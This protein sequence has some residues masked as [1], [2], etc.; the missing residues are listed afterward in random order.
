MHYHDE[1]LWYSATIAGAGSSASTIL[2]NRG[3]VLRRW[4]GRESPRAG[5]GTLD[6]VIRVSVIY[7]HAL[8]LHVVGS[9]RSDR[10]TKNVKLLGFIL[11]LFDAVF[12]KVC[13]RCKRKKKFARIMLLYVAMFFSITSTPVPLKVPNLCFLD[14]CLQIREVPRCLLALVMK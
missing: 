13:S 8:A 11:L 4:G 10:I 1:S 2:V 7:D 9:L 6:S 5:Q 14:K 12:K 3:Q